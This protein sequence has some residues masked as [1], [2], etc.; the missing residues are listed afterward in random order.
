MEEEKGEPLKI[1][2]P[3]NTK[4]PSKVIEKVEKAVAGKIEKA[5]GKKGKDDDTD[6]PIA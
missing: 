4:A 1:E 5:G 3:R 2:T 6:D